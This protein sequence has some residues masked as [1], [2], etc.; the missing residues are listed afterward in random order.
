MC[1]DCKHFLLLSFKLFFGLVT[2]EPILEISTILVDSEKFSGL[3]T[4]ALHAKIWCD[5]METDDFMVQFMAYPETGLRAYDCRRKKIIPS[6][7]KILPGHS[8]CQKMHWQEK[9]SERVPET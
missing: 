3:S 9:G 5:V 8:R 4:A 6:S 1:F 2:Q 7:S